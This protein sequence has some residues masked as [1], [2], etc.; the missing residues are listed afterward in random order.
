[1][2]LPQQGAA[3]SCVLEATVKD[4]RVDG[5]EHLLDFPLLN[6]PDPPGI[7]WAAA[8]AQCHRS[9]VP[10]SIGTAASRHAS[11][12]LTPLSHDCDAPGSPAARMASTTSACS[13]GERHAGSA[14]AQLAPA[15]TPLRSTSG[16][17]LAVHVPS[18]GPY[19]V[20]WSDVSD[21]AA[22]VLSC[23]GS[24]G[25]VSG[26][27]RDSVYCAE[28]E[29]VVDERRSADGAG[30][31]ALEPLSCRDVDSAQGSAPG[32]WEERM[33]GDGASVEAGDE[34]ESVVFD[35]PALVGK[36]PRRPSSLGVLADL[37]MEAFGG[38][39]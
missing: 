24:A 7:G 13:E 21:D 19:E 38:N 25:A 6:S 32:A 33:A 5:T 36:R 31:E 16:T 1:M 20:E 10:A 2:Q 29:A 22:D 30:E 18:A 3:I 23:G 9:Y 27:E 17:P 39:A 12:A 4:E 8:P 11:A 15:A 26:A 37:P 34:N 35:A 28:A 14:T